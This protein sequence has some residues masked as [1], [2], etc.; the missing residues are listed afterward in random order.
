M[1]VDKM[2][3]ND[4]RYHGEGNKSL[5]VSH[6]QLSK[7]LRL[8]KYPAED[9]ENPPQTAEQAFRQIQNIVDFS[10]NVMSG[11]LGDKFVHSGEVVKLPMEFL[12]QLSIKVQ[13]QRPAWRRDKVMDIYS[14]CA[15]C[16]PNLTSPAPPLRSHTPPLCVE[17]K[18]KCG[19]L[20]SADHIGRDVKSKVCRFCMH[21]HYKVA[22]GRWKRRSLYCPLDLFSGSG[23]R[24]HFAVRQL[25]EE[26]QNNFKIFK[27]GQCIYSGHGGCSEDSSDLNSLLYHLRPYFLYSNNRIH[28]HVSGKAVLGDFIQVLVNA[29]LN[30][31]GGVGGGG[32]VT[33]RREEARSFC[34]ASRFNKER[35]R[36]DVVRHLRYGDTDSVPVTSHHF[37]RPLSC[38]LSR[39]TRRQRS[40]P[41]PPDANVGQLEHRRPLSPLSPSGATPA[42]IPKRESSAGGRSLQRGVSRASAQMSRRGRRLAGLCRVQGASVPRRH[43]GQGLL[44]HGRPRALRRRPPR[45]RRCFVRSASPAGLPVVQTAHLLLLGV[46]PGPGPQALGQHPA[47]AGPGPQDR[48]VLHQDALGRSGRP[49]RLHHAALQARLTPERV[50]SPL[51]RDAEAASCSLLPSLSVC[52]DFGRSGGKFVSLNGRR[53]VPWQPFWP[54]PC[55][56]CLPG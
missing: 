32:V 12:R 23:Q 46:H 9:S 51:L 10:S 31:G 36:H 48:V 38:R 2:D 18:P 28:T 26:P 11:L 45:R 56:R 37:A 43:D 22:N 5:V 52:F 40:V 30:G 41:H 14:G 4:W 7:V 19:F 49:R 16:L 47:A 25:I 34:E 6:V 29:L 53:P 1:E 35:S 54:S 3:E 27:G 21:Q 13:H 39:F 8:L 44:H 55:R 24:M 15:L 20:P 33:D 50:P 42:Q 17:I